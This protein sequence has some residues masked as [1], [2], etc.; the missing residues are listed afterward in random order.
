MPQRQNNVVTTLSQ[1]K[2]VSIR[3]RGFLL[4]GLEGTGLAA[5]AKTRPKHHLDLGEVEI[6]SSRVDV[7][8]CLLGSAMNQSLE[9]I[10]TRVS[11][12]GR[13]ITKRCWDF[14]ARRKSR[15]TGYSN[16]FSGRPRTLAKATRVLSRR[17]RPD[18]GLSIRDT[19][20]LAELPFRPIRVPI[21]SW[22][23]PSSSNAR[24]S[25]ALIFATSRSRA[26][27]TFSAGTRLIATVARRYSFPDTGFS[28]GSSPIMSASSPLGKRMGGVIGAGMAPVGSG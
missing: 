21:S 7:E 12:A 17:S 19:T 18:F 22:V 10:G 6:T 3:Y 25:F 2:P 5:A 28:E 13:E 26:R 27:L 9:H 1:P 23:R 4:F 11:L 16:S 20:A 8:I 15:R 14:F 24:R